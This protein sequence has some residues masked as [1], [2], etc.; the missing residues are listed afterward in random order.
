[1]SNIIGNTVQNQNLVKRD[2]SKANMDFHLRNKRQTNTEQQQSIEA[3]SE[4]DLFS[5]EDR[6][7]IHSIC[8]L[9]SANSDVLNLFENIRA[10]FTHYAQNASFNMENILMTWQTYIDDDKL[11]IVQNAS[12]YI[13]MLTSDSQIMLVYNVSVRDVCSSL[14]RNSKSSPSDYY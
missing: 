6:N 2:T 11:T 9:L 13:E 14:P 3:N 4:L 12:R 1:M 5:N 10:N 8:G 7:I